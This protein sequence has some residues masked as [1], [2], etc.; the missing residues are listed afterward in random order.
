MRRK[1]G[2]VLII[3]AAL[4]GASVAGAVVGSVAG[5]RDHPGTPEL[6]QTLP[7]PSVGAPSERLS[8]APDG[9]MIHY[10]PDVASLSPELAGAPWLFQPDGSP[11]YDDEATRP[12]LVFPVGTTHAEALNQLYRSVALAGR[13]PAKSKLSPPLPAGKVFSPGTTRTG[14]AIDLRAPW[15][16][17][18]VGRQ[19]AAP[20]LSLSGDLKHEQMHSLIADAR[21]ANKPIP[22]SAVASVPALPDCQIVGKEESC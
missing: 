14:P 4:A 10:P 16:Y 2:G 13:L 8:P 22:D 12:S 21:A 7:T 17:D 5:D 6:V 19:I 18:P 1:A 11:R 9:R 3:L 20:S 15:G